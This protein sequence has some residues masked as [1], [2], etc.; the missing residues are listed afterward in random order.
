MASRPR[1]HRPRRLRADNFTPP[2]RT[3]WG[4]TRILERYKRELDLDRRP[5]VVGESWEVSIEP[6]FPSRFDDE[7][8]G[9]GGALAAAIEADPGG[10]LGP[11]IAARY[12]SLP[13]L[14]KLLDSREAL[15]L[16]VHPQ[17]DDPALGPGE[18]GKPEAWLVLDADPGAGLYLGFREGVGRDEVEAC[19]AA[20]GA[21]D[22]LMTF[23]PVSPGDAFVIRA[24]TPHAIGG[25]VTLVEPQLVA[26]GRR[27]V[28][29]RFWDWNR[30]YAADGRRSP[31]GRPRELHLARSLAVTDWSAPRGEAFV[32]SCRAAP[33]ALDGGELTRRL[34]VDEPWARVEAWAGT[35][36][37][38]VPA[39]GTLWALTCVAGAAELRSPGASLTM[40][41]GQ[42]VV[43]PAAVEDLE[44]AAQGLAL[45]A[46]R[47]ATGR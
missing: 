35:G 20:G 9:G 38:R 19:L 16:Q 18:S 47:C 17:D 21:L 2:S 41:C 39:A 26:P 37:W 11:E 40:R 33:R 10:W 5:A 43:V 22:E 30:R 34:I 12:G 28:T 14:V 27:G 44:L 13:L 4:G 3:P 45:V 23:V 6:S 24:G 42:S 29:Y 25:G 15:S 36:R 46:T 31:S 8:D 32:A 7:V 1:A